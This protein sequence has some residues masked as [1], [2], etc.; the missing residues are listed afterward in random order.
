MWEFM[1][2]VFTELAKL[3]KC[4]GIGDVLAIPRQ[5]VIYFPDDRHC[6]VQRVPDFPLRDVT[7]VEISPGEI[8][9]MFIDGKRRKI[10]GVIES[11]CSMI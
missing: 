10:A 8:D 1:T 2:L 11:F 4:M 7:P 5:E 9:T 3:P 6:N